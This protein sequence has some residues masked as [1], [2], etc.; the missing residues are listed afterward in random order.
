M[1]VPTL[2]VAIC[3]SLQLAYTFPASAD[4]EFLGQC[5]TEEQVTQTLINERGYSVV[6]IFQA[7]TSTFVAGERLYREAFVLA[8]GQG[9][10]WSVIYKHE[11]DEAEG[12]VAQ[13]CVA[14][15]GYE[16]DVNDFTNMKTAYENDFEIEVNGNTSV[17]NQGAIWWASKQ[18]IRRKT[19][20]LLD[21]G[22]S[23][24]DLIDQGLIDEDP[25]VDQVMGF[26]FDFR[27]A[28]DA[29]RTARSRWGTSETACET[30]STSEHRS[31][32]N[33]VFALLRGRAA[34]KDDADGDYLMTLAVVPESRDVR[35]YN[36]DASGGTVLVQT[37]REYRAVPWARGPMEHVDE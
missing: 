5:G 6:A 9:G 23:I 34:P 35:I 26:D 15:A 20:E 12:A 7:Y 36:T 2:L 27:Q 11:A 21:Q 18:V 29:C 28:E 25:F 8:T 17:Q 3:L 22:W 30:F 4:P 37:G 31:R 32:Q 10:Q 33:G 24:E 1:R 16:I 14:S 13:F 19:Q